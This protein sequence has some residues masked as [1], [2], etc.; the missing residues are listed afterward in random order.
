[1]NLP[2][3]ARLAKAVG[4]RVRALRMERGWTLRELG[5]RSHMGRPNIGRV[6]AG[7]H[8]PSL[9]LLADVA[10]ALGVT[11]SELLEGVDSVPTARAERRSA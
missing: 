7:R 9:Q 6:E 3:D 1:M 2:S 5:D 4:A 10:G 8:V 11:L